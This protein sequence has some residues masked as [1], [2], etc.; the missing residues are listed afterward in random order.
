MIAIL[1]GYRSRGV[2]AEFRAL[3][4][5][6]LKLYENNGQTDFSEVRRFNEAVDEAL[7]A[8]M[9]RFATQTDLFRDQFIGVLS[10]DLRTPLGTITAGLVALNDEEGRQARTHYQPHVEYLNL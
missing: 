7:P 2:L 3:R 9:N 1:H 10:H 6:V 8:F 4:A 5:S